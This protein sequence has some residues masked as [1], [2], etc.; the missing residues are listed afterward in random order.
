LEFEFKFEFKFEFEFE[1]EF[2]FEW[3]WPS[4]PSHFAGRSSPISSW[5]IR[6]T[7]VR[8]VDP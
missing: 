1:F 6:N 4:G 5:R 3:G 8:E 7:V 2:G